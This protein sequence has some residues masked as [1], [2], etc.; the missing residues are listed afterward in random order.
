MVVEVE[1]DAVPKEQVLEP[2]EQIEV[3]RVK[4]D[5][6]G[7]FFEEAT[8]RGDIVGAGPWYLLMALTYLAAK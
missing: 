5:E 1:E 4:Q 3:Y 7:I 2:S 8:E 6:V